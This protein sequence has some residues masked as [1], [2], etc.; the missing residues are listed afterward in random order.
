MFHKFMLGKWIPLLALALPL[1]SQ[2]GNLATT[3]DGSVVLFQSNLR[4]AGTNDGPQIKVFRWDGTFSIVFS[5]PTSPGNLF[6]ASAHSPVIS[7]DGKV[8]GYTLTPECGPSLGCI[9]NPQF[10]YVVNGTP[11][12]ELGLGLISRNGKFAILQGSIVGPTTT[13]VDLASGERVTITP[14][15]QAFGI[16][17]SGDVLL[18]SPAGLQ[19]GSAS[20]TTDTGVVNATVSANGKRVIYS[21]VN[22][23]DVILR[24]GSGAELARIASPGS[25][26]VQLSNDGSRGLI[27][28]FMNNTAVR[29]WWI[30][31][32][33]P[34][35]HD[36][37]EVRSYGTALSGDGKTA[38]VV[39]PDGRLARIKLDTGERFY[40]GDR[41]PTL[42][43][44]YGARTRG[45]L[46]RIRGTGLGDRQDWTLTFSNSDQT[47]GVPV[48]EPL[49]THLDY[50]IPWDL[51][52]SLSYSFVALGASGNTFEQVFTMY[53]TSS[54]EPQFWTDPDSPRVNGEVVIKV[55]HGDFRSLVTPENPARPGEGVHVYMTGL[56]TVVP[57]QRNF[58]PA[59]VV[60]P[61]TAAPL[62]CKLSP[63]IGSTGIGGP[64]RVPLARLAPGM[65]GIYQV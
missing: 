18:K 57:A 61:D 45:S 10:R 14:N 48:L 8:S 60:S 4:L 59:P 34:D 17:D 16:T 11:H 1:H 25:Y 29:T 37:G 35:R 19:L 7:G 24:D 49:D 47:L 9:I 53:G 41:L 13:R 52:T 44:L 43:Q 21:N 62:T 23:S 32:N 54:V 65:V 15:G 31:L 6:L 27:Q 38:W 50:Q 22:G 56:G 28:E 51:P 33:S 64:V 26:Q 5:P 55:V 42:S 40:I 63:V 58:T 36:L 2:I 3:D 39:V 20:I 46:N 12:T 30:D